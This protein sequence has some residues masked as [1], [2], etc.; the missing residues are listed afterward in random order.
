TMTSKPALIRRLV[1]SGVL[2]GDP[3]DDVGDVLALVDRGLEVPVDVLPLDDLDRVAAPGEEVGDRIAREQV[4]LVLEAMDLDPVL[5]EALEPSQ[6]CERFL[7]LLALLDD[8]RGL[9]HGDRAGR[10]DPIE[11]ERVRRLLDEVEDVI[12]GADEPVDVLAIEWRHERRLEAPPDL[13]A[14]LVAE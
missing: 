5:L 13:V 2:D 1:A 10:L 7:E 4:A 6:V 9:L 3:L 8:D 14:D 12:Q 11:D